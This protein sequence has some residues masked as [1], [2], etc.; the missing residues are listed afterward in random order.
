MYKIYLKD[1]GPHRDDDTKLARAPKF[2]ASAPLVKGG[3]DESLACG[4]CKAVIIRGV[5]TRTLHRT[6]SAPSR[7]IVQCECGEWSIVPALR[8][9][10]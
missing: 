8:E 9:P 1:A 4:T 2:P 7:L 5:T 6:F 10:A 3:D